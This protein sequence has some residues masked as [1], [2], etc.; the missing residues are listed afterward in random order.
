ML[1][2]WGTAFVSITRRQ[3]RANTVFLETF[4]L[5]LHW[6]CQTAW[7]LHTGGCA[8]NTIQAFQVSIGIYCNGRIG[9]SRM[10]LLLF[11]MLSQSVKG[12]RLSRSPKK[13]PCEDGTIPWL[14]VWGSL[15]Y[16]GSTWAGPGGCTQQ[17]LPRFL[18]SL[19]CLN[20]LQSC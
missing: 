6:T 7:T 13:H 4:H 17:T 5:S 20:D 9:L 14:P 1:P 8:Q 16:L 10:A 19:H 18:Q 2:W 15:E 12:Q 11:S 3:R